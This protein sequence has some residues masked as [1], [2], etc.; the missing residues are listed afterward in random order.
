MHHSRR[1]TAS[2]RRIAAIAMAAI[3]AF[4]AFAQGAYASDPYVFESS[5]AG[6]GGGGI[7]VSANP[8][9]LT[10]RLTQRTAIS[11]VGAELSRY[12]STN[13]T[14][15]AALY[16]VG[17]PVSTP[18]V[19]NDGN[20]LATA[21]LT[22]DSTTPVDASAPLSA[23]LDP[24]WYALVIG[25]GRHGATAPGTGAAAII[26]GTG[27]PTAAKTWGPYAVNAGTNASSLQ[28]VD[29]RLFLRGQTLPPPTPS[30]SDFLTQTT[31]P[32]AWWSSGYLSIPYF[33]TRFSLARNTRVSRTSAW[34]YAGGS[35]NAFAAILRL[36]SPTSPLPNPGTTGFTNA[37]VASTLVPI[38]SASDEYAGTFDDLALTPG[39]YAL[40]YGT[41]M[42]GATGSIR[43]MA[44]A[45]DDMSG[46]GVYG[47]TDSMWFGPDFYDVRMALSGIVPQLEVTPDPAD[48]G[49]VPLG[50][51]ATRTLT[52]KNIGDGA[53]QLGTIGIAGADAAQ[54]AIDGNVSAC[55][56]ALLAPSATCAFSVDYAPDAV[57]NHAAQVSI[58]SDGAPNPYVV[59]LSGKAINAPNAIAATAGTPQSATVGNAFATPLTVRVTNTDGI[60]V[61]G[62]DVAFAAPSS[63]ASA[64]V[65]A[66]AVTDADGYASVGATANS[67]VGS[68]TVNASVSGVSGSA[69]FML[70]NQTPDVA[71][72]VSIDDGRTDAPYASVLD[73]AIVVRNDGGAAANGVAVAVTLPDALDAAQAS[74]LCLDASGGACTATGT[75][76]IADHANVP[77]HGSVTYLLSV[78]VRADAEGVTVATGVQTSG[79]Y[80]GYAA[81]ATDSDTLVIFRDG[82]DAADASARPAAEP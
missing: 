20:L 70:E 58:A 6:N 64:Q 52:V 8:N 1:L 9:G 62:I 21:L 30:P 24:G 15:Y 60:G 75:G 53:L 40:V 46:S 59:A 82:F 65:A 41:G 74:W 54:F 26:N 45:A 56:G 77:A 51:A 35:G 31:Q 22:V 48:F 7:G 55:A 18:D 29:I 50:Y 36:D 71:I 33:A 25:T 80:A 10:F 2:P 76:A 11:E 72:A 61:P 5:A 16:R 39:S 57:G 19:A 28:G 43:M 63:G 49:V 3:L 67:I 73:Y 27:N 42:F 78:P 23:T 14:V 13:Y 68:Y 38:G 44:I 4:A 47:W 37:V 12:G 34:F 81:N 69:Q 66:S 79:P 17:T 32:Y